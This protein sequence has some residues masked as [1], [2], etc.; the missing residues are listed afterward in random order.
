MQAKEK[1]IQIDYLIDLVLKNRWLI[2]IPFCL[3]MV[4]G[5]LLIFVLP[6]IYEAH[7]LIRVKPQVVPSEYVQP[8]VTSDI[9]SRINSISR[10]ILTRTNLEKIINQFNLYMEPEFEDMFMEDKVA[11]LRHRFEVDVHE[12]EKRSRSLASSIMF[13]IT[14]SWPDS[15]LV[16]SVVNF[17][18]TL[19]ID[20][21]RRAREEQATD[22]SAFLDDELGPM[23]RRLEKVEEKIRDFRNKHM[24][25]L[26]E[27][28]P[29][30]LRTL[31]QLQ[32]QLDKTKDSLRSA[33]DQ[34]RILESQIKTSENIIIEPSD[35]SIDT[36]E[37]GEVLS[38]TLLKQQLAA[39]QTSY[40]DRHPDIIRLKSR[41]A[42]LEA[43]LASGAYVEATPETFTLSPDQDLNQARFYREIMQTQN[44]L[45]LKHAETKMNIKNLQL[46]I[47]EIKEKIDEYQQ[48]IENTPALEQELQALQRDYHNVRDSHNYLLSRKLEA[49]ISVNMEKKQKGE[50][51]EIIDRAYVPGQPIS[52]NLKIIFFITL[53][54]SANIGCGLVLLKDYLDDSLRRLE[55]IE[56]ELKISV[57]AMI[58]K[59]YNTRDFRKI[60]LRKV[61]TVFTLLLSVSLFAGFTILAFIGPE[62]TVEAVKNFISS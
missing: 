19:F 51:F 62:T 2:I 43:K 22:T 25:E 54:L 42:E 48:R 61:M 45:K 18:A 13:T 47:V 26:P 34:L 56:K 36:E 30:N 39:L 16:A 31:D 50:Q 53:F 60:R 10:Q 7:T 33:T 20:E 8:I 1:S 14:F 35:G 5:I 40:T 57:L 11:D 55:D 38:L 32:L 3:S 4:V 37:E 9:E 58:P 21:N 44:S 23:R 52:P 6:K 46:E 17:V 49:N 41:I 28:L 12:T 15:E 59:I 24:G 27:Q 29:T